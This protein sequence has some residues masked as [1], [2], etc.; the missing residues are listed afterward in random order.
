MSPPGVFVSRHPI[1]TLP[2]FS[3]HFYLGELFFHLEPPPSLHPHRPPF[4]FAVLYLC[5]N[6]ALCSPTF[7]PESVFVHFH[8]LE[9]LVHSTFHST[10]HTP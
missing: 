10:F 7:H 2:S 6:L 1:K 9:S 3:G 5:S 8:P 4:P